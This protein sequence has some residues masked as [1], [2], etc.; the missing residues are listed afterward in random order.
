MWLE[1]GEKPLQATV[2]DA[3]RF[4]GISRWYVLGERETLAAGSEQLADNERILP[5]AVSPGGDRP[6][7]LGEVLSTQP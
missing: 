5:V 6:L 1:P 4:P 7:W 3:G 2:R